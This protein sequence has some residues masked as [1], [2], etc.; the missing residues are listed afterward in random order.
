M[1]TKTFLLRLVV[2]VTAM[3]CALGAS[4]YDFESG[5]VYYNITGTNT[6]E[7]TNTNQYGMDYSGALTI[8]STVTNGGKTYTVTAIGPSAFRSCYNLT[9]LQLPTTLDSIGDGAFYYTKGLKSLTIPEGVTRIADWNFYCIDSLTTIDMPSSLTTLGSVCFNSCGKL[10]TIIC[11]ATTPPPTDDSWTFSGLADDCVLYVPESS[12][13][14][15]QVADGWRRFA[16]IQAIDANPDAPYDFI[17][18]GIYYSY[19]WDEAANDWGPGCTN[20]GVIYGDRNNYNSYS[21]D[22]IIPETVTYGGRTYDVIQIIA[23]TF[24][25]STGLTSV[26]IPNSVFWISIDVFENCPNLTKIYCDATT[27]PSLES[28]TFTTSQYSSITLTVPKG[29]KSAYQSAN[30]WKNFTNIVESEYDFQEGGIYYSITGSNT[31]EVTYRNKLYQTYSGNVSIPST[32][33]HAGVTYTVAGIGY[34]AFYKSTKLRGVTIPS[35]VTAIAPAAFG[36]CENLHSVVIPNGVTTIPNSCFYGCYR[37]ERVTIPRSVTTIEDYAFSRCEK[38]PRVVIPNSVTTIG[39]R[40]FDGCMELEEVTIG[41]GVTSIG[42]YALSIWCNAIICR[43]TTPPSVEGHTFNVNEYNDATLVVPAGRVNAYK[44][45]ENWSRFTTV[46]TIGDYLAEK[47]GIDTD[48]FTLDSYGDYLWTVVD[49]VG[50]SLRSGNRSIHSSNSVLKA[51]V[52][53]TATS[54]LSFDFRALGEGVNTPYDKC[55]FSIDGVQQFCYGYL[56]EVN[57]LWENSFSIDLEPGTHTLEWSYTKDSSVNSSYDYFEI[58]DLQ[59]TPTLNAAL[60]VEGG[61]LH[62]TTDGTYPWQVMEEDGRIYAQSGN[63]G[64]ASSSSAVTATI[65]VDKATPL[66]FDFKAW[67]EGSSTFWDKCAFSI[68]G[69]EVFTKGAYKNADWE[70]YTA[71]VPAGTH[72]LTW[73]YTKDD[74]VNPVGDFFAI[75]NVRLG[76]GAKRGDVNGDDSVSI[77]DVTAL[78]DYLLSGDASGINMSAA[79]CNQDNGVSIGDVTALIDYLLSGSW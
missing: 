28:T 32:V 30:Y 33:T 34:A 73:S 22:V 35:T 37:M 38:L 44:A 63:A 41:S 50:I 61:N 43:A 15:Y 59:L 53:V 74:S 18:D 9:S 71:Q 46:K 1:K 68:D 5:N 36:Y 14:A 51:T 24:K 56:N 79:D 29:C 10:S 8:P 78:I 17:M 60:N 40:A 7:V 20:V 3:M 70:T 12:V 76:S 4:A 49:E 69:S 27:P 47:A 45:A 55:V 2:L 57:Y 48:K 62:F 75:D 52:N 66:S 64:V 16:N 19:G 58:R 6:V 23:Y 21:G 72:T 65:T 13:G 25:N 77:G 11:R 42:D 67:G 54:T 39:E 31:V 26:T